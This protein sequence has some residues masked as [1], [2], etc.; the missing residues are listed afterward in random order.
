[1]G[2]K[3]KRERSQSRPAEW[4]G[5]RTAKSPP[6]IGLLG[7]VPSVYTTRGQVCGTCGTAEE[8]GHRVV[9]GMSV[10]AGGVIGPANER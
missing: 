1:M 10:G 6:G 3:I 7:G 9:S 4:A 2:M 5:L 8:V